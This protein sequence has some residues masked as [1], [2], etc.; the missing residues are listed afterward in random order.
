[1]AERALKTYRVRIDPELIDIV[2]VF[3]AHRWQDV[4]S[5][6]DAL[7]HEDSSLIRKIAHNLKGAGSSFGFDAVSAIGERMERAATQGRWPAVERFINLLARYLE[8]VEP[9]CE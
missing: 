8:M 5:L 7:A 9:V 3:I 2:P 4:A 6:Q 1:M